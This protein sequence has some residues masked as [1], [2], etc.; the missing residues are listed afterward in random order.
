MNYEISLVEAEI[1]GPTHGRM[2]LGLDLEGERK[3]DLAYEWDESHFTAK[4]IGHAESLPAPA[5]PTVLLSKPIAAMYAL[6]RSHHRL[7]TD[8][9]ED[10]LVTIEIA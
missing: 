10:N 3:A 8:V 5:H 6:K 7:P 2:R 4:F 9:F 1:A